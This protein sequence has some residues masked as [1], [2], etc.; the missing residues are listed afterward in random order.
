MLF[1]AME[2]HRAVVFILGRHPKRSRKP[3]FEGSLTIFWSDA[4]GLFFLPNCI[5]NALFEIQ[6]E[7]LGYSGCFNEPR[8]KQGWKPLA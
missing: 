1:E 3:Y 4:N 6:M 7:V 5:I 8:Y 2:L